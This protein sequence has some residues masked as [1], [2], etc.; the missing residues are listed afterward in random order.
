MRRSDELVR[1]W[2]DTRSRLPHGMWPRV[3]WMGPL[4]AAAAGALV[5]A[6]GM[7]PSGEANTGAAHSSA[8]V[9]T[10]IA[11]SPAGCEDQTWPYFSGACLRGGQG[12]PVRV[13]EYKPALAA[14]AIGTTQ[15]APKGKPPTSRQPP[16][17]HQ[18]ATHNQDRSVTA[19]SGRRGRNTARQR[20][21]AFP[22]DAFRA[23]GS[24]R[25]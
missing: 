25:R 15:W 14:A 13:L 24:A 16:S 17:R 10:T 23:Y 22:P 8:S 4:A 1:F 18:Q 3:V 19:R 11:N 2:N 9:A 12:A 5:I 7:A 21:Y 6:V 20:N